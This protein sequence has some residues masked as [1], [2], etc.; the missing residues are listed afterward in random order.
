MRARRG[1]AGVMFVTKTT[2]GSAIFMRFFVGG[3]CI[4][5]DA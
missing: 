3:V 5:C 4:G 1:V 2:P